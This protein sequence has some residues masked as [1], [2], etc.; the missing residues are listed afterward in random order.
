MSRSN[1]LSMQSIASTVVLMIL[2]ESTS[3]QSSLT[4]RQPI[5][6]Q[7]A[8]DSG[9]DFQAVDDGRYRLSVPN[10]GLAFEIDRLRR[11]RHELF[12]ELTVYCQLAG[13]RTVDGVLS[14]GTF[15]LSSPTAR[16]QRARLLRDMSESKLDFALMLEALCLRTIAAERSGQPASLLRD[17]PKPAP[18]NTLLVDA[19]RCSRGIRSSGSV[20]VVVRSRTWGCTAP[21]DSNVTTAYVSDSSTGNWPA[22][23]IACGSSSS[24]VRTCRPS[25]TSAA[26]NRWYMK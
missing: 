11:E 4:A 22:R 17:I 1:A 8:V 24:L 18:D 19:C 3:A 25:D 5:V 15:N 10:V 7:P 13:A 21:A 12:G 23:I 9:F 20:T 16:T 6:G 14:V 2:L 26:L